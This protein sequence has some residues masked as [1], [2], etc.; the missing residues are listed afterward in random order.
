MISEAV[1]QKANDFASVWNHVL[2][3]FPRYRLD[4]SWESI[5][6]VDLILSPLRNRLEIDEQ[7]EF[8]LQGAAAYLGIIVYQ[9]WE[10]FPGPLELSLKEGDLARYELQL[11]A[12]GGPGLSAEQRVSIKLFTILRK[13]LHKPENPLPVYH[14]EPIPISPASNILSPFFAGVCSG[15]SPALQGPW[16][17]KTPKELSEHVAATCIFGA[18]S[19]AERYMQ[20]YPLDEYGADTDFYFSHLILPPAGTTEK[21]QA[22]EASAASFSRSRTLGLDDQ[23][24]VKLYENLSLSMDDLI[25]KVGFSVVAAMSDSVPTGI[26]RSQVEIFDMRAAALRQAVL[27]V[28]RLRELEGN[29]LTLL[30][31]KEFKAAQHWAD[32]DHQLGL[33]PLL[34]FPVLSYLEEAKLWPLFRILVSTSVLDAQKSLEVQAGLMSLPPALVAQQAKLAYMAGDLSQAEKLLATASNDA[35]QQDT[36]TLFLCASLAGL[37]ALR[38]EEVA[39]AQEYL[40]AALQFDTSDIKAYTEVA[41]KLSAIKLTLQQ[42]DQAEQIWTRLFS[43]NPDAVYVR[44]QLA[45]L[46]R[47]QE[48]TTS[49]S[50]EVRQVYRIAPN[51]KEIFS[52][53]RGFASEQLREAEAVLANSNAD[54]TESTSTNGRPIDDLEEPES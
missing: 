48:D 33:T 32:I 9:C 24:I 44:L 26:L 36:E 19:M 16:K 14:G 51:N 6:V 54:G 23:Q 34:A 53:V 22:M 4:Y 47:L 42:F 17:K 2:M 31:L 21:Y 11:S 49:F 3:Q 30:E 28:R 27:M 46:R 37:L 15:L 18:K 5:G 35:E 7:E 50:E 1:T 43:R 39:S 10:T 12:E 45:Y 13:L 41:S 29:W 38:K 52:L 20:L 40:G 25:S 8:L